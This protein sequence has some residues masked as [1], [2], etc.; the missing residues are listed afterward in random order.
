M[1]VE[2]RVEIIIFFS[3]VFRLSSVAEKEKGTNPTFIPAVFIKNKNI[4]S[5]IKPTDL[6]ESMSGKLCGHSEYYFFR[7]NGKVF[8][9]RMCNPSTKEPTANQL[10]QRQKFA[11]ARA[12][13]KTALANSEQKA[14]YMEAFKK[15][16]K[17]S[18][19]SG[20]V[21]AMEYAKLND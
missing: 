1:N 14:A 11:T 8:S 18:D 21:F 6:V 4:M 3:S 10:A 20:Y 16:K 13:A 5:R 9:G 19:F 17:Y 7:K 12:N 2:I 15:Q